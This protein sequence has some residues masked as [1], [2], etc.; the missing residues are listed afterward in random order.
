L[1]FFGAYAVP[2]QYGLPYIVGG[3]ACANPFA[4][5]RQKRCPAGAQ[6]PSRTV[7]DQPWSGLRLGYRKPGPG[8]AGTWL[9][10]WSDA[11]RRTDSGTVERRH[12]V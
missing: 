11:T 1:V 3:T 9:A 8:R 5:T 7:L 12:T 4:W 10:K 6:T 2:L